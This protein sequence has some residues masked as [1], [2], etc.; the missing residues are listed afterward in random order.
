MSIPFSQQRLKR[1]FAEDIEADLKSG[2]AVL[3]EDLLRAVEQRLGPL[4][5]ELR[6]LF[7]TFASPAVPR[8]G[9]PPSNRA[10]DDFAMKKVD[11]HYHSLLEKFQSEEKT[12]SKAEYLPPNER[13]YRQLA[14]KFRDV[15][16]SDWRAL[17]NKHSAWKNGHFHSSDGFVDSEDF[18][19]EIERQFPAHK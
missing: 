4:P 10:R 19:A 14:D 12:G 8:R 1:D 6:N 15:F 3:G 11:E 5:V 16:N 17:R 13:A 2:R 7:P 18:D 9:R